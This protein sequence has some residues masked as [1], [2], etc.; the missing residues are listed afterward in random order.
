MPAARIEAACAQHFITLNKLPM[1]NQ[2]PVQAVQTNVEAN[3]TGLTLLFAAACGLVV[4]NLYYAQPLIA[5]ISAALGISVHL[6]GLIVTLTQI[7]YGLGLVFIVP[8]A[9]ILENRRLTTALLC[10]CS[11]A[12][13]MAAL[14]HGP[15]SFFAA[16]ACIGL[17]SVAVQVMVPFAAH[18]S[19]EATRGR[20]V[21]NVMSGLLLG[22][23]LARPAASLVTDLWGWHA[24]FGASAVITACVAVA[25]A[26][27]LPDRRPAQS[28][29]YAQVLVSM[30]GLLKSVA[31]LRRRATSH[32]FLF[33]AFSLFWTTVPLL[34]ASP[35]FGLRQRGI[36]L[37][38]LV[39]V[40]GAVAAPLAG[41]LADKG[42]SGFVTWLAMSLVAVAFLMTH[43][44]QP[45]SVL[46][47]GMLTAAAIVLDFGVSANLVVG[48]RAIYALG[49]DIRSRLNGV[50]MALFFTGGAAGSAIGAW[51]YAHGGW[52]LASW[53]GFAMPV[54][55]MLYF[56]LSARSARR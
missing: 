6:A 4:A 30:W 40:A 38:A 21:G 17:T 13:A 49:A 23:M 7:G 26:L 47:L 22:I 25:V 27:V 56:A 9:D 18:L 55:A 46:S 19:P 20:T 52:T 11:A 39:G 24:I 29:P 32:A 1:A 12:L 14:A 34:L 5:P 53:T 41:R 50:F 44:G 3:G 35:A 31:V 28:L 48:Q 45:G 43:V 42:R 37:F 15:V 16:A 8:A 33:G 54:I 2:T 51:T 10:V 36:A